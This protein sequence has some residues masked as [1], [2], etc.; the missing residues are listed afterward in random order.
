[1][2]SSLVFAIV[3]LAAIVI[4]ASFGM[5]MSPHEAIQVPEQMMGH[6]L[7]V[8]PVASNTWDAI[9]M[10]MRPFNRYITII[11]FFVSL[12]LIFNWGWGMYQNLLNDK[13]K[14]DAFTNTWKFTK[15]TFWA[16][17]IVLLMV[18]TPNHFRTVHVRGADGDWVLCDS[19]TPGA[20]AVRSKMVTM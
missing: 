13:F 7:Y 8:C 5:Q 16:G 14:R 3:A 9:A 6:A 2:K 4:A 11:F 20:R 1:L 18:F 19:N 17:I 15:F 12:I 10:A